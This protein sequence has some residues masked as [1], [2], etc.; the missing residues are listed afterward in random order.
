MRRDLP[1]GTVTFVFTDVEGSTRLLRSLGAEA[2]AKALAE[3]RRI[4]RTACRAEGGVEVDTQGDAFFLAFA[5]A[6]GA[7]SAAAAMTAALSSGPIKVRIG[8]HTGTPLLADEGYVGDDV[9]FAARVGATGHGGQ[10]VMSAS[11]AEL[12]SSDISG[13]LLTKLGEHRLKDIDEAVALFQLGQEAFPPLK[14]ISNTNLPRPVSSFL[15]RERELDDVVAKIAGGARLTTLTGPGGTGKTRLAIEA[16]STLIG[17]YGAG[18][19]WVGLAALRDPN[20]VAQTIAQTI[21]AKDGL[22]DH[23]GEREML[24]LIDNLEQVV[25]C[26]PELGDLLRACPNLALLVTSRELL[27]IQGEVEYPVPPLAAPTAVALFCERAAMEA[28]DV[29]A[30]LCARLDFLPLAVEL[31]AARTKSLSPGKILERLSH[32]LDLLK[33]GRDADPRQQTLRATIEWSYDLLS[34]EERDLFARLSIFA[35]GWTLE[36]AE[37]VADA[38]LDTLQSLTEKSLVRFS[39]DRY[40]MLATIREYAAELPEAADRALMRRHAEFFHDLAIR[41]DA[42]LRGDHDDVLLHALDLEH[43]NLR[44]ALTWS[45]AND[46]AQG[47]RIAAAL[48]RFW[49]I[50]GSVTEAR[51]WLDALLE[52]PERL[53]PNLLAGGLA[54]VSSF[55]ANDHDWATARVRGEAALRLAREINDNDAAFNAVQSL[56]EAYENEGRFDDANAALEE[57]IRIARDAGSRFRQA[58]SLYNHGEFLRERGDLSRARTLMEEALGISE[59]LGSQ[60]G[61]ASSLVGIGAVMRRQ[62]QHVGS[63]R[64]LRRALDGLVTLGFPARVAWCLTEVAGALTELGDAERAARL[65]GAAEAIVEASGAKVDEVTR[66]VEARVAAAMDE[67]RFLELKAAGRAMTMQDAAALAADADG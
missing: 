7:I 62:G 54:D 18:V 23:I 5:T 50:R 19:F 14:T 30:E 35:G 31:A 36:G 64:M 3:H 27:R 9:H 53:P 66:A 29:I 15:G 20:L 55:A 12:V 8:L 57:G 16:A 26:A 65:L 6:A 44:A 34:P 60:E 46:P 52:E 10:V 38:D 11:T 67:A 21:G 4:V 40:L 43:D 41:T 24:L 59:E 49:W 33:G 32:R 45:I 61:V 56:S 28:T 47:M 37:A 63:L 2:Y 58:A 51:R 48:A 25:E 17:K 13:S 39:N 22:A 1:S 42:D